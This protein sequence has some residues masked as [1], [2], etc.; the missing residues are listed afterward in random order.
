[1]ANHEEGKEAKDKDETMQK[2]KTKWYEKNNS[3]L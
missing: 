3:G 2:G 1:M